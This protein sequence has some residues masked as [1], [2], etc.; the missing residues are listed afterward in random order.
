MRSVIMVVVLAGV[1]GC[2]VWYGQREDR[3]RKADA[4]VRQEV[5]RCFPPPSPA[6]PTTIRWVEGESERKEKVTLYFREALLEEARS[7]LLALS[8]EGLAIEP[9]AALRRRP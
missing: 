7:A 2:V 5:V 9:L 3:Q 6:G 1:V 8:A 4:K